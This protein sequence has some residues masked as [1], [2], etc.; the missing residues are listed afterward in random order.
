MAQPDNLD[1]ATEII[2]TVEHLAALEGIHRD[3]LAAV[4][5]AEKV[6]PGVGSILRKDLARLE[7]SIAL[8]RLKLTQL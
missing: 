6:A 8:T 4:E 7:A 2:A 1:P 5:R 3:L